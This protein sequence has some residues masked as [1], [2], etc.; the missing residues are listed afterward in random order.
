MCGS[1][2]SSPIG[3]ASALQKG[4]PFR[5]PIDAGAVLSSLPHLHLSL[6]DLRTMPSRRDAGVASLRTVA[7]GA[8]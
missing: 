3:K 6:T 1:A 7:S 2:V 4:L 5:K 8:R